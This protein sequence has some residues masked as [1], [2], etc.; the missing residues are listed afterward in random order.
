MLIF[1]FLIFFN[2]LLDAQWP[3]DRWRF[4]AL[5]IGIGINYYE[6]RTSTIAYEI[7]IGYISFDIFPGLGAAL[8]PL[9]IKN[10]LD[11]NYFNLKHQIKWNNFELKKILIEQA[12]LRLTNGYT[13]CVPFIATTKM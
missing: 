9:N 3:D 4:G 8:I 2:S 13:L 12:K 7:N 6:N 11:Y 10:M 5:Q 1:L